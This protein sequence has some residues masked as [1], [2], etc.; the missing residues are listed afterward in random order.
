MYLE[1][2]DLAVKKH[3]NASPVR[4]VFRRLSFQL[5]RFDT[6]H[7]KMSFQQALQRC[8]LIYSDGRLQADIAGQPVSFSRAALP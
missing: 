1:R 8:L 6:G 4:R 3:A 7:I 2:L 5:M